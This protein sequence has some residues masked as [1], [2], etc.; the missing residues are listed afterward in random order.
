MRAPHQPNSQRLPQ[1]PAFSELTR[2]A[3]P[4]EANFSRD[5]EPESLGLL[6]PALGRA[7]PQ[8]KAS[9]Q[10]SSSLEKLLVDRRL[11]VSPTTT[12]PK[13]TGK[14]AASTVPGPA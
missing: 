11:L 14:V 13:P 1:P 9:T 2:P 4:P 12:W 7:H 5:A 10:L 8:H 6:L 3:D